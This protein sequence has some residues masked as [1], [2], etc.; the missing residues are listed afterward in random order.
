MEYVTKCYPKLYAESEL[1]QCGG[2]IGMASWLLTGS[3]YGWGT[4][5]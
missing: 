5:V 4:F 1:W 2:M 3:F